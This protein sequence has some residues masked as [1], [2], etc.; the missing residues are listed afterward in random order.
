[1]EVH[2]HTDIVLALIFAVGFLGGL[3]MA[4]VGGIGT[5]PLT[6]AGV[7]LIVIGFI[8]SFT[9]IVRDR[10]AFEAMNARGKQ[11]RGY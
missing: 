6:I 8:A 9:R 11:S 10:L 3:T 4:I 2:D 5:S 1:M 7:C